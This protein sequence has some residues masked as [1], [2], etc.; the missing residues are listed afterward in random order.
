[1][2]LDFSVIVPSR[3]RPREL[4]RCLD[5]LADLDFPRDRFEIIVVDDG[6]TVPTAP[7]V[8]RVT[9]RVRVTTLRQSNGGPALARNTGARAA[10]GTFLA[11]TDDDCT[12]AP[13][14]LSAFFEVLRREP[15]A[16]VGGRTVN[17][18]V[19]NA[20]SAASQL[21][22]DL[23]YD[24]Y[25]A[26]PRRARFFASNNMALSAAQFRAVGGFDP[27]FRTSEDRD[28][29]DRW[30]A[31]GRRMILAPNA[32]VH[33]AHELSLRAFW[34][35]HIGYGRGARR[36]Y[37]AHRLRERGSSTIDGAFYS[38]VVQRLPGVLHG[39]RSRGW[40]L[41][42]LMAVWQAANVAG[43][44]LETLVP[45]MPPHLNPEKDA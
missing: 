36:F 26:E 29:C 24:Y 27:S 40:S 4:A 2:P 1:M 11:F 21:I 18:L 6:G 25:N 31:A 32:V 45:S 12:P 41:A 22:Q 30:T 43:F 20:C 37:L 3:D 10:L 23:V 28:L 8:S 38:R 35:Q 42:C 33:H 9:E 39:K 7:I 16:M 19:D 13:D 14:W 5:S 17:A 15:G 34:M 44:A